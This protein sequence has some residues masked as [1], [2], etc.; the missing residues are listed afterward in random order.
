MTLN[1]LQNMIFRHFVTSYSFDQN[2]DETTYSWSVELQDL[3]L[4]Y[5]TIDTKLKV[6]PSAGS[7]LRGGLA[8][9]SGTNTNITT[10]GSVSTGLS[11][12]STSAPTFIQN[13]DSLNLV[14]QYETNANTFAN[15]TNEW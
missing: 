8:F 9:T 7:T 4:S 12:G 2:I 14:S 6:L 15:N 13:T 5:S 1:I 10:Q 11:A 3:A